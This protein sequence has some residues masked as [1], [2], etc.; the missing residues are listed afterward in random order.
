MPTTKK[1]VNNYAFC[2]NQFSFSVSPPL[3]IELA[4]K[5]KMQFTKGLVGVTPRSLFTNISKG[6]GKKWDNK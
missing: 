1:M 3:R 6:G 4:Q 5:Q 2:A